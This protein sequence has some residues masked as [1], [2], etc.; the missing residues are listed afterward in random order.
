MSEKIK[1][2]RTFKFHTRWWEMVSGFD[3]EP[4]LEFLDALVKYAA[5][6]EEPTTDNPWVKMA[7][8][9]CRATVDEDNSRRGGNPNF[10]KGK[11]NPY[12]QKRQPAAEA[13]AEEAV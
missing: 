4:R 9:W 2:Q 5:Y 6:G 3:A 11:T 13:Q 10:A 7:F 12:I 8:D 1:D